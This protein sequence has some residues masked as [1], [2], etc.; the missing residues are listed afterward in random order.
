[1]STRTR[2]VLLSSIPEVMWLVAAVVAVAGC[3]TARAGGQW[4]GSLLLM[5]ATLLFVYFFALPSA[6]TFGIPHVPI[7][8]V[9]LAVVA[10]SAVRVDNWTGG[11]DSQGFSYRAVLAVCA[12]AAALASHVLAVRDSTALR[13]PFP[14]GGGRWEAVGNSG[15]STEPHL[16]IHAQRD[17][18]PLRLVFSDVPGRMWPGRRV[19][20]P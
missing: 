13:L 4:A 17:D 1:M 2:L 6:T 7:S 10:V 16:H 18:R 11:F 19:V 3:W 20:H 5:F 15:N 14:V 8:V 12:V 9:L